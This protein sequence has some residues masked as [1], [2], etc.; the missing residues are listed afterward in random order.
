MLRPAL[1]LGWLT[2]VA[3]AAAADPV[4][5]DKGPR[6][7]RDAVLASLGKARSLMSVCWQR[8]PPAAVKVALAVAGDGEVTSAKPSTR[9]AAAQCAAGI[10]AVSTLHATGAAWKGTVTIEP[11]APG[12]AEDARGI[13]EA[14]VAAGDQLYACGAQAPAFAGDVVLEVKVDRAGKVVAA[15]GNADGAD[16]RKVGACVARV[17]QG[18]A[19]PALSSDQLTYRLTLTFRGGGPAADAPPTDPSLQPSRKGPLTPEQ[20]AA[21]LAPRR[22]ALGRCGKAGAAGRVVLRLAIAADGK[23]ASAKVKESQVGD[24]KV[25]AC[26]LD[27]LRPASFPAASGETV[28]LYPVLVD[29]ATVRTPG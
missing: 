10:L 9:G 3:A 28:V 13:H 5:L 16:G 11:P 8:T 1:T 6:Q 4:S 25:E 2:A 17:A 21:A 12:R 20:L 14:L 18:L 19:M 15:A 22:A 27:A 23:V 26:L 29:G 7:D 24:A